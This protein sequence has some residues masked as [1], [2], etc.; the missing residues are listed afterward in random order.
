MKPARPVRHGLWWQE[1][2]LWRLHA[3]RPLLGVLIASLVLVWAA[4]QLLLARRSAAER[5]RM[6]QVLE[7]LDNTF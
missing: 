6:G 3:W 4:D 2:P 7:Q 5:E 1:L